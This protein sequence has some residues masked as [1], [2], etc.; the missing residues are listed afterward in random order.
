MQ[1]FWFVCCEVC[2]SI[3]SATALYLNGVW[4]INLCV[5]GTV[6]TL[7]WSAIKPVILRLQHHLMVKVL[8]LVVVQLVTKQCGRPGNYLLGSPVHCFGPRPCHPVVH[9]LPAAR[10][11]W[12]D[13]FPLRAG[14]GRLLPRLSVQ[15]MQTAESWTLPPFLLQCFLRQPSASSSLVWCSV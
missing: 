10:S 11:E 13:W 2:K 15:M 5:F 8:C 4:L 14:L 12:T 9:H 6:L 3:G 1:V 7:I